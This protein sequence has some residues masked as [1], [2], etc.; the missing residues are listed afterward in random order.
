M[1]DTARIMKEEREEVSL[2]AIEFCTILQ[3]SL[4]IYYT[5]AIYLDTYRGNS[6]KLTI[7]RRIDFWKSRKSTYCAPAKVKADMAIDFVSLV[8]RD[9]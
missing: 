6:S 1:Q 8:C 4:F 5:F 2:I 3:M 7:E 9:Y